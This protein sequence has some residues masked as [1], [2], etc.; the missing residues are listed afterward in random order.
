MQK[1][2][3]CKWLEINISAL[4]INLRYLFT[5]ISICNNKVS[6]SIILISRDQNFSPSINFISA[7]RSFK[8]LCCWFVS[9]SSVHEIDDLLLNCNLLIN[10][11][12]ALSVKSTNILLR[13]KVF[14][15]AN[16]FAMYQKLSEA[17]SIQNCGN[18]EPVI[19]KIPSTYTENCMK[20]NV[21]ALDTPPWQCCSLFTT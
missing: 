1:Q 21:G 14:E 8:K 16:C 7:W 19:T 12:I 3:K 10:L 11:L 9:R 4:I 13:L 17:F 5:F 20:H 18:S 15:D 2:S 6:W